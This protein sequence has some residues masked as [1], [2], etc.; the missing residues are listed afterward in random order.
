MRNVLITQVVA[1]DRNF[2][3]GKG[4][5]LAWDVPSDM[6]HFRELTRGGV[7]VMGRK[8]F[9]SIGRPLPN[10][11]NWVLTSDRNWSHDGVNTSDS[12]KNA[13]QSIRN[14]AKEDT[15]IFIIGGAEVYHK[16]L[17]ITDNLIVTHLDLEVEGGDAFYPQIPEHFKKISS[18]HKVCDKSNVKMEFATYQA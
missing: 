1:V 9:E 3:I 15:I 7:V 8:T 16:S 2:C 10:R 6:Q 17:S 14:K 4:N 13:I 18:I 11:E 12:L 5:A